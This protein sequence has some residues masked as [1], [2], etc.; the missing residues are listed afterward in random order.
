MLFWKRAEATGSYL[1]GCPRIEFQCLSVF[2]ASLV[3]TNQAI[4]EVNNVPK[5]K[6]KKKKFQFNQ[7]RLNGQG[8]HYGEDVN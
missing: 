7:G 4:I 6:T 2:G 5:Y 1:P 8:L 3:P